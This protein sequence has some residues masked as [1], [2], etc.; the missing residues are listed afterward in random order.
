MKCCACLPILAGLVVSPLDAAASTSR[1]VIAVVIG[2]NLGDR[3]DEPLR[4][5]E[6][7]A[8]RFRDLLIELG[9]LRAQRALLILGGE[10]G[11]VLQ[12]LNE[13]R[14]RADELKA[15][16]RR[17]VFIFYYSG[18]G[19]DDSLH[20]SRG[21][22][23]LGDLRQAIARIPADLRLSF[24]DACR[25]GGRAK[26]VHRGPAFALATTPEEPRGTIEL[27]A[28]SLGEAAQESE[29]LAGAVFTHFLLSGLRGGADADKDGSV[30]LAELYS[31]VY[32][33]TLRRTGSAPVLQHPALQVHLAGAGEIVLTRPAGAAAF[34]EVSH[35]PHRYLVF[36]VP[37]DS[38]V[39]ELSSETTTRIGLPAGRFM[40]VRRGGSGT[41]VA[42]VDL[43]WGGQKLL[44]DRDFR[45]VAREELVARGGHLELRPRR[46]EPRLGI[47]YAPRSADSL[48][49]R[50][51]AAMAYSLGR[52]ELELEAAYV[53][54]NFSSSQ[55]GGWVHSVAGGPTLAVRFFLG[56]ITAA[57][58]LG[59]ELRYSWENLDRRDAARAEQAG[60]PTHEDRAFGSIGP[61]VGLRLALPLGH[62]LSATMIGSFA[63]L[64]R[65]E[66][67]S[68]GTSRTAFHPLLSLVCGIGYSF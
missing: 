12:A 1:E 16:G 62:N 67:G 46:I 65:R 47:E 32:R 55:F 26:G 24:L 31:Y 27:R 4:F 18:H 35:G 7:D 34:L 19:D 13:A 58:T 9:E 68:S 49:L 42:S 51:G 5:A 29:Q 30:T 53:G 43:S 20:L 39:G 52:L 66:A 28:S 14:G 8:R 44:L 38:I 54:G 48:A 40:V 3:D 60:L 23:P 45:P 15:A 22:L 25:T 56:R 61:R 37:S 36:A 21:V 41:S 17:V 63:A 33:R 57:A 10:P 2:A 64:F 50:A 59:V 6:S 11:Q